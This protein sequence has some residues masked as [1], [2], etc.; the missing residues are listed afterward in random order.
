MKRNRKRKRL[1]RKLRCRYYKTANPPHP[2]PVITGAG[3][4]EKYI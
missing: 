4:K 3:A 2:S 1:M